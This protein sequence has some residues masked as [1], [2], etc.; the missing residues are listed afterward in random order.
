MIHNKSNK[1]KM[2][3]H[4]MYPCYICANEYSGAKQVINHVQTMHGCILYPRA[5]GY[6]RPSENYYEFE[7][8][9]KKKWNVQHFGC[10]SC[11]FHCPKNFEDLMEHIM[12][13][14]EPAKIEGFVHNNLDENELESDVEEGAAVEGEQEEQE[15]DLTSE[16]ENSGEKEYASTSSDNSHSKKHS[17][18]DKTTSGDKD[19]GKKSSPGGTQVDLDMAHEI[20]TKLNDLSDTFKNLFMANKE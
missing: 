4:V 17:Q 6:H 16:E 1:E 10:P 15:L 19:K 3:V 11:W 12:S 18:D 20:L 5:I 8:D 7:N 13:K 14:H 2:I 9:I